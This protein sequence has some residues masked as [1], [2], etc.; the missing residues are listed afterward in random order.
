MVI[1]YRSAHAG[2]VPAIEALINEFAA[3][4]IMLP[5]TVESIALGI[6][7][8]IVATDQHG[9]IVGCAA[10][11][12]YS[13]SLAEVASVAVARRAHGL[14]IGSQLVRRVEALAA[15]RGIGELFALT[16]AP[17]F[18]DRL[19]YSIVDRA[20]FPEKVRADCTVCPRRHACNE[21]CV[22]RTAIAA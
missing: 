8:F 17:P 12:E 20:R 16:L 21:I 14:G 9:R 5:K 7:D 15:T 3:E 13:P 2:D 1:A 6:E 19:G 18:F 11:R 4:R 22:A 10:L